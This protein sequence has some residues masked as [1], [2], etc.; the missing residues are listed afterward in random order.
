[1]KI[2]SGSPPRII[3]IRGPGEIVG[4]MAVLSGEPRS[5]SVLAFDDVEALYLPAPK[6]LD[7]LYTHPRA[8]HALAVT[9]SKR[10]AESDRTIV[11]SELAIGQQLAL[12]LIKLADGGLG[13]P[14]LE[15]AVVLR[16]SQADMAELIG[17]K[18][19]KIDSVKKVI[20]LLK[21]KG[22]V[23]AGYKEITILDLAALRD[24]ANGDVA[25]SS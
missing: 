25:V 20:R 4:E 2:L 17:T 7:F 16:L 1:V 19:K 13:E 10:N 15:N 6:W 18:T 14:T 9:M 11:E 22:I 12:Q 3:A 21:A 23:E 24:V 8:M 5:A